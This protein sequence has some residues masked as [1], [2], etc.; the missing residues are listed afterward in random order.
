MELSAIY[1][2]PLKS[3]GGHPL[4]AAT[5]DR[6]GLAGDRRWMLVDDK[7]EFYSQRRAPNMAL[8]AVECVPQGL[9]L[10]FGEDSLHVLTP[11]KE[12]DEVLATV[13]GYPM[14]VRC[15][16]GDASQWISK[17]L[18]ASLRLVFCPQ[19]ASRPVDPAFV[20]G[21]APEQHVGFADGFPLLIVSQA[22]L[23][24]L[25]SRL[26][27]PVRMDRFRPNLVIQ[28]TAPFAEDRWTRLRIGETTLAIVKPCSRCAIPGIDQQ[29]AARDPAINR[30]L[31]GYRRRDGVIYFGMNALVTDGN[32]FSVGD[33]V[34]ALDAS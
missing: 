14:I 21:G 11:G 3:A 31:A 29:T 20:P 23:D 15:A 7:G 6:F 9:R 25:N 27:T 2:Y 16:A 1:R 17:Q 19:G 13:W 22:S 5:M 12:A 34:Q 10:S 28:G 4:S 26:P 18:G 24:D 32:C 30:V 8:L 33:S